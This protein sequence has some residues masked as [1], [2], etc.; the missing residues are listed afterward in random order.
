MFQYVSQEHWMNQRDESEAFR[1]RKIAE[2]SQDFQVPLA[3]FSIAPEIKDI[4]RRHD[5]TSA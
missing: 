4:K 1:R 2:E 5:K 3:R